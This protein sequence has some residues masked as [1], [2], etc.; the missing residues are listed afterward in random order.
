MT[1]KTRLQA[2][3]KRA[4]T[5]AKVIGVLDATGDGDQLVHVAGEVMTREEFERLYGDGD[6]VVLL[7]IIDTE[8]GQGG[9]A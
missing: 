2:I 9:E 5:G 7:K 8:D 1:L 3:E 6:N 4:G